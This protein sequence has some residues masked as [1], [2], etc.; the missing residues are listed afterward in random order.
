MK[1]VEYM[2]CFVEELEHLVMN[3]MKKEDWEDWSG[4]TNHQNLIQ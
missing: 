4:E 2:W 3:I 1:I